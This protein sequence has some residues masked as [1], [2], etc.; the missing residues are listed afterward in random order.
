MK[1]VGSFRRAF[2]KALTT[3]CQTLEIVVA[4]SSVQ[5]EETVTMFYDHKKKIAL[6][7]RSPGNEEERFLLQEEVDMPTRMRN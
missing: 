6:R 1:N 2:P 7:Y 4:G 5:I 3:L